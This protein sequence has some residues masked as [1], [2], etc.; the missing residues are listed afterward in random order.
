MT[1]W[2]GL[3]T[4]LSMTCRD[5]APLISHRMDR[6]LSAGEDTALHVHLAI[7]PACRRYRGQL[8]LLRQCIQLLGAQGAP[9][10]VSALAPEARVR[11]REALGR[12]EDDR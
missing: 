4:T 6:P 1:W 5:A 11:I 8:V 12:W 10:E 9:T 7:C 2:R 3:I